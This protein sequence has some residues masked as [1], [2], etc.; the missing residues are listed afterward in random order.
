MLTEPLPAP[1]PRRRNRAKTEAALIEAAEVQF[2]IHG[3]KAATTRAIAAHAGCSEALIQNYFGGKDGLLLAVMR[4]GASEHGGL[5]DE[6][7]FARPP[8]LTAEAEVRDF[9]TFMVAGMT[10]I[11]P[12]LRI[13][14]DRALLGS[15][16]PA[17][18]CSCPGRPRASGCG[19]H[20]PS[21][22]LAWKLEAVLKRGAGE[23]LLDTYEAE[24]LPVAHHVLKLSDRMFDVSASQTGWRAQLRD[25]LASLVIGPAS[26]IDK[27]QQMAFRALS[28]IDLDYADDQHGQGE[29]PRPRAGG[30]A[31]DALVR[32]GRD[33]FDLIAGYG[34]T[35]LA[36]SRRRLSAAEVDRL[37]EGLSGI[38][39]ARGRIVARLDAP[40]HP[41][42]ERVERVEVWGRY[43]LEANDAQALLLVRPDGYIAWRADS[44]DVPGCRAAYERLLD[45]GTAKS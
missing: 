19:P 13:L 7:F 27:L 20:P 22:S 42:V 44:L 41:H 34:F 36:L 39:G 25:A 9:L 28:Q 8:A 32:R 35:V 1:E 23:A 4:A 37:A 17:A 40:R 18:P 15:P 14:L 3:F 43:R 6:T 12:R 30:R 45:T 5:L 11:A 33:V 10:S 2:S 29:G 24:R 31:P 26:Q 38:A 16:R 21:R